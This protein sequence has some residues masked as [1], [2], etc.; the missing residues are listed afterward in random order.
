MTLLGNFYLP[1]NGFISTKNQMNAVTEVKSI[2][3][4]TDK[5]YWVYKLINGK[6]YKALYNASMGIYETGW[7][8]I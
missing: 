2:R 5:K 4:R 6:P 7:I 8:P 3:P 1:V